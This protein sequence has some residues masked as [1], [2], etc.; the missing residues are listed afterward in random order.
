MADNR[1]SEAIDIV[2]RGALTKQAR[3]AEW[4]DYPEIGEN[5]WRAVCDR[6]DELAN[7]PTGDEFEAAY[8]FLTERA[9]AS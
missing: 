7:G 8:Q 3:E 2:A 6:M 4:E 5:D 1:L 9:E